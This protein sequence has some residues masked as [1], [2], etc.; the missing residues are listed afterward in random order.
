[1]WK[2]RPVNFNREWTHVNG[3][4]AFAFRFEVFIHTKTPRWQAKNFGWMRT[5]LNDVTA[6]LHHAGRGG[7]GLFFKA[8]PGIYLTKVENH[9][10]LYRKTARY[11]ANHSHRKRRVRRR[12]RPIGTPRE[13]GWERAHRTVP[14]HSTK[15]HI[16]T[17]LAS[18]GHIPWN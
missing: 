10:K 17:P 6:G 2:R 18:T 14:L 1:M 7:G 12:P 9:V 16:H 13:K 11:G 8:R 15:I 5:G 4:G 3:F